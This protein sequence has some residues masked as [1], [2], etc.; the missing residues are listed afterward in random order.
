[1][2]SSAALKSHPS[3]ISLSST[4]CGSDHS[5]S[6]EDESLKR[7]FV[8]DTIPSK[9]TWGSVQIREYNRMVGD[10]PGTF[11][12]PP[13]TFGWEYR[14]KEP[15][16]LSEYEETR[17]ERKTY[18]RLSSITR[19]NMLKNIFGIDEKEIAASEKEIQ[20]I[21][22]QRESTLKQGKLSKSMEGAARKIRR[23]FS[24]EKFA[25]ALTA[26]TGGLAG[27]YSVH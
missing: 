18:L 22:K 16:D 15:I 21:R 23:R 2:S 6:S 1:M 20:R 25:K 13:I 10:H 17:V 9:L 24:R 12:G 7:T 3:D 19:K 5:I 8:Q 27:I 14:E 4:E 11:I 26:V